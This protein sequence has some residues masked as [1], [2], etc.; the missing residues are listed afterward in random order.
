MCWVLRN[1]CQ[2]A[3]TEQVSQA[4]KSHVQRPRGRVNSSSAEVEQRVY[5]KH[6]V[7]LEQGAHRGKG[8]IKVEGAWPSSGLESQLCL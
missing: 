8:R 2:F 4:E 5:L 1:G 6:R 3:G 7:Q